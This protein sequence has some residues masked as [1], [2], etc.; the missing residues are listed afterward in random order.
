M[1]FQFVTTRFRIRPKSHTPISTVVYQE[2]EKVA[3]KPPFSSVKVFKMR[4][5]HEVKMDDTSQSSG[6]CNFSIGVSAASR[7]MA[8][9]VK[10][11]KTNTVKGLPVTIKLASCLSY[12]TSEGSLSLPMDGTSMLTWTSATVGNVKQMDNFARD[13]ILVAILHKWFTWTINDLFNWYMSYLQNDIHITYKTDFDLCTIRVGDKAPWMNDLLKCDATYHSWSMLK[14]LFNWYGWDH[15]SA[16][17]YKDADIEK[18]KNIVRWESYYGAT[19]Y[20]IYN[21]ANTFALSMD[22]KFERS[23]IY[24]M[25]RFNWFI[26]EAFIKKLHPEVMPKA[27]KFTKYGELGELDTAGFYNYGDRFREGVF[28]GNYHIVDISSDVYKYAK[29]TGLTGGVEA[30]SDYFCENMT[31][32]FTTRSGQLLQLTPR[33]VVELYFT[34]MHDAS[35][36]IQRLKGGLAA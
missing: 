3:F 28:G 14:Y 29:S 23:E 21:M 17:K 31:I 15:T 30:I 32:D 20:Y 36:V 19:T 25:S 6:G 4:T 7:E 1:E 11:N 13:Q 34:D 16:N 9:N 5:A 24:K 27:W 35:E 33:E 18:I 2:K 22:V 12:G 26:R 8:R 10:I